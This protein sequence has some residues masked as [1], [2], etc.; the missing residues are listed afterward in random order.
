[1]LAS[2]TPKSMVRFYSPLLIKRSVNLNIPVS[3]IRAL[4][5]GPKKPK[6]DFT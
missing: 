2:P 5:M 3:K 4:Q 1:M 6:G